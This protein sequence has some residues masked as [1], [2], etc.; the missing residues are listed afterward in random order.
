MIEMIDLILI[1]LLLD[2]SIVL[3][4][5]WADQDLILSTMETGSLAIEVSV[6]IQSTKAGKRPYE[7]YCLG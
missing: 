7:I 4:S 6:S 1:N 2:L 5:N 3:L